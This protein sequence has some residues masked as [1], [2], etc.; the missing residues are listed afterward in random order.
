M[1]GFIVLWRDCWMSRIAISLCLM[2]VALL[3]F[4][5]TNAYD[6]GYPHV[7]Q[8]LILLARYHILW[9]P[10]AYLNFGIFV[11]T[12]LLIAYGKNAIRPWVGMSFRTP[13]HDRLELAEMIAILKTAQKLLVISGLI[14]CG[15]RFVFSLGTWI[16]NDELTALKNGYA[17]VSLIHG[18][19]IFLFLIMPVKAYWERQS[20]KDGDYPYRLLR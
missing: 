18:G 14:I 12:G 11:F 7:D 10:I 4:A 17:L 6:V 19:F 2:V 15:T 9:D 3:A 16:E 8:G 20:L 13:K 1:A 5:V